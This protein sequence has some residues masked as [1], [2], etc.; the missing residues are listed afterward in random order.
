MSFE[1]TIT[2]EGSSDFAKDQSDRAQRASDFTPLTSRLR[3]VFGDQY[4]RYFTIY[5]IGGSGTLEESLTPPDIVKA[6]GTKVTVGTDVDYAPFYA[7]YLRGQG[8]ELLPFN[9]QIAD[10]FT[11]TVLD[12]ILEGRN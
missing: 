11:D 9:D 6:N 10:A 5:P 1:I 12:W 7:D 2:W 8:R 3:S 4:Q